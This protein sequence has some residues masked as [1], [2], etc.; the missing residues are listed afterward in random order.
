MGFEDYS[1]LENR[2]LEPMNFLRPFFTDISPTNVI[3]RIVISYTYNKTCR[4]LRWQPTWKT[5]LELKNILVKTRFR[6]LREVVFYARGV[7]SWNINR[8]H[9]LAQ[10]IEGLREQGI[11]AKVESGVFVIVIFFFKSDTKIN[12]SKA[13]ITSG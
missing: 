2:L 7:E 3:E 1:G 8:D 4:E 5:F 12:P 6:S 13:H 11:D 10:C 9:D